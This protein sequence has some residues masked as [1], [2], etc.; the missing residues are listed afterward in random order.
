MS[1]AIRVYLIRPCCVADCSLPAV[2]VFHSP[3]IAER[4]FTRCM[5]PCEKYAPD[6]ENYYVDMD[7]EFLDCV[8]LAADY[9][10]PVAAVEEAA[11]DND[12]DEEDTTDGNLLGLRQPEDV[13]Q[14]TWDDWQPDLEV[15]H[16]L[17]VMVSKRTIL[18]VSDT[19]RLFAFCLFLF[20]CL[21]VKLF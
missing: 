10:R 14:E 12:D 17:K 3:D 8:H 13:K 2:H 6:H 9:R 19:V 11:D 7:Y 15:N 18:F 4:V 16:P 20:V 21:F 1:F 5:V